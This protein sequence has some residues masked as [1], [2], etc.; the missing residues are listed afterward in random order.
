MPRGQF[1]LSII[2]VMLLISSLSMSEEQKQVQDATRLN[3]DRKGTK[4]SYEISNEI[5]VSS[6]L[7][8]I[9]EQQER[10]V[11]EI[12]TLKSKLRNI[13]FDIQKATDIQNQIADNKRILMY[14][15]HDSEKLQSFRKER[16]EMLEA[17][18]KEHGISFQH[19][20]AFN[21][22]EEEMEKKVSDLD[23]ITTQIFTKLSPEV[24]RRNFK[25]QITGIFAGL[26]ALVILGFFFIANQ[27]DSIRKAIFSGDSG[28][29]FLTLFSL[30]IAIILFGITGILE[31]RELA[32]L[33]GGISSY[34]LGRTA[35]ALSQLETPTP[36]APEGTGPAATR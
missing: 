22:T 9:Q 6:T 34:I 27:D 5:K 2:L 10:I 15:D 1:F 13:L 16:I 28:I 29:Q 26:V 12:F 25:W 21:Q 8:E 4:E 7:R 14:I 11:Q 18:L 33:L 17:R 23:K 31:G 20:A 35:A 19:Q 36:P 32:A 3:I 24:S 30:V